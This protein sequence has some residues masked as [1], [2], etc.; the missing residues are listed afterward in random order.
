M[1]RKIFDRMH[2]WIGNQKLFVQIVIL[3]AATFLCLA[4][5]MMVSS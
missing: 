4:V 1:M 5:L 3:F 2:E